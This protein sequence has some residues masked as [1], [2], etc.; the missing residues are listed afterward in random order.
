MNDFMHDVCLQKRKIR[1]YAW[2]AYAYSYY[3]GCKWQQENVV[4]ICYLHV[5]YV[6]MI[7]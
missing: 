6:C 2:C 3:D 5:C 1:M 4:S 7:I